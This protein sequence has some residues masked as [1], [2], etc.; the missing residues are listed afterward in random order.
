MEIDITK[1]NTKER[2]FEAA[3][4]LFSKQ[5]YHGTSIRELAKAVG[6]KESSLYNHYS[7]K[8]SIFDAILDYQMSGFKTAIAYLNEKEESSLSIT[9]PIEFW[10]T[11]TMDFI[12]ALPPLSDTIS[13]IV[14]NEMFLNEQCRQFVLNSMYP[15]LKSLTEKL[16][17]DMHTRGMIKDCD[18]RKT[19]IQY[20]YMS[21]GLEIENKLL[22]MEGHSSEEH[23]QNLI[24]HITLFIDG[25]KKS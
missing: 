12:R 22:F 8:S 18:I 24:E 17:S 14:I 7:G 21:Q 25:L 3:V 23:R 4:E 16:L 10:L 20:V 11:G 1:K 13:R 9:D 15:A 5:G 19:A 2:I 6:I